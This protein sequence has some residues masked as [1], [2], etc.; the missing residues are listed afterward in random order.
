MA[1]G[2][3]EAYLSKICSPCNDNCATCYLESTKCLSCKEGYR[4]AEGNACVGRWEVRIQVKFQTAYQEFI[5][6]GLPQVF[7]Q[8]VADYLEVHISR[9]DLLSLAEGSTVI[10]SSVTTTGE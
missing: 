10:V 6:N 4:L 7:L 1:D 2:N 3:Q 8:T 9:V 5:S